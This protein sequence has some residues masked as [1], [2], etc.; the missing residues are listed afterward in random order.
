MPNE[1][2][3]ISALIILTLAIAVYLINKKLGEIKEATKPDE[4]LKE[5]LK[6]Q[7]EASQSMSKAINERLDNAAR[8]IG[9]VQRNIGEMS[10]IGRG[11]KDLQEFLRSPKLR[12]NIG[13]QVL[14]ELLGQMLPKQSFHLQYTFK[15]G[16][17]VDAAIKTASGIIPIDSKFPME[18]FRKMLAA[19]TEEEKKMVEKEFVRDVKTHID[20]IASKYIL[21]EEGTIDYALMYIPAEAVYYEI[22]NN[23]DLFDYS[24]KKRVLPVSPMT[25]YAYLR[26]ILMS[27]E[28][29]K[30]EQRARQILAAIRA[31]QKDYNKVEDNLSVLGR[32]IQN[33]Y[34]QM[35]NVMGGFTLLGQ[36]LSS[37][38]ALGTGVK[39]ETQEAKQLK[40][41]E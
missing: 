41:G 7:Q 15:S 3:L 30:I 31:V 33:A 11:M 34:N 20:D 27:F 8:V 23:S 36:K 24:G 17:T 13:E 9:Q 19:K 10:E 32:H 39:E 26:A 1:I 35:S 4:T 12:G 14:K 22:V 16:A 29:Q 21:T 28:G 5:W 25:F 38:Q 40:I 37:T 2:Y 18:N 6:S